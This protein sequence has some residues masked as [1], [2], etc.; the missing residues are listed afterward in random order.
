VLT[1]KKTKAQ[2]ADKESVAI[3][4]EQ[5]SFL[6][7]VMFKQSRVIVVISPRYYRGG[8]KNDF[9]YTRI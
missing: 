1:Q 8:K 5:K 7:L 4:A 2:N 3:L 6:V 9:Q